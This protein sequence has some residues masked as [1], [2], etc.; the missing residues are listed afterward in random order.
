MQSQTTTQLPQELIDTILEIL[1]ESSRDIRSLRR[2]AL[3]ARCFLSTAR[4]FIYHTIHLR[5]VLSKDGRVPVMEEFERLLK[6]SPYL[7][8]FIVEL[9]LDVDV[10]ISPYWY[11][12][13]RLEAL[14]LVSILSQMHNLEKISIGKDWGLTSLPAAHLQALLDV[15]AAPKIQA[16]VLDHIHFTHVENLWGFCERIAEGRNLRELRLEVVVESLDPVTSAF[17]TSSSPQS[18]ISRRPNA[19]AP[20]YI[21][22]LSFTQGAEWDW[23]QGEPSFFDWALR[24][25]SPLLFTALRDLTVSEVSNDHFEDFVHF[26]DATKKTLANLC[27][28]ETQCSD[29]FPLILSGFE[30]LKVITSVIRSPPSDELV[31]GW[32]LQRWSIII[33]ESRGLKLAAFVILIE[34]PKDILSQNYFLGSHLEMSWSS[35]GLALTVEMVSGLNL[36]IR[37]K[38]FHS[39]ETEAHHIEQC[40][41]EL[42]YYYGRSE[43]IVEMLTVRENRQEEDEVWEY[44]GTP[45]GQMTRKKT[46]EE[47]LPLPHIGKIGREIMYR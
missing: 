12:E 27:I 40:F 6:S 42:R 7:I 38:S 23:P 44:K 10:G 34:P 19:P 11:D 31:V 46:L 28:V 1:W 45:N 33:R 29:P 21:D 25:G 14:P 18:M 16:I 22:T 8:E 17:Y 36:H 47:L 13:A 39:R 41:P 20:I 32:I 30:Q 43:L 2:C 35:L 3:S 26:L 4:R 37:V 5:G 15:M 9:I 24:P